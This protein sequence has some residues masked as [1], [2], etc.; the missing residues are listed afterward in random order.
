M[1]KTI[2]ISGKKVKFASK[3]S[4]PIRYKA[5]FARDFFVDILKM[6]PL[7]KMDLKDKKNEDEALGKLLEVI[8]FDIFYDLLWT[9]AKTADNN[10]PDKLEWLD[11]FD[12]FPVLDLIA[13]VQELIMNNL[14][15]KK[16]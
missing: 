15:S 3:G 8:D 9:M 6:Y 10:I 2:T 14:Q 11:Q 12:S 1:E 16:K 7:A 5:Q 4:T 13:D